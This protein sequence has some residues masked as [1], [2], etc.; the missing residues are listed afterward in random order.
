MEQEKRT[1]DNRMASVLSS[2][3]TK[4][5]KLEKTVAESNKKRHLM[6]QEVTDNV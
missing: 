1:N 4:I 5:T 6:T 3:T 2:L